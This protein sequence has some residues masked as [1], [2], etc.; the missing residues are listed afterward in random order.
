[1]ELTENQQ[2]IALEM[3]AC[4]PIDILST[5]FSDWQTA[6]EKSRFGNNHEFLEIC[7]AGIERLTNEERR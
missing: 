7:Y 2:R 6:V 5:D 4:R 1:M 3:Q